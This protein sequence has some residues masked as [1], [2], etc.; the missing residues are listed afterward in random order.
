M[1]KLLIGFLLGIAAAMT[2]DLIALYEDHIMSQYQV[3]G[4]KGVDPNECHFNNNG[5]YDKFEKDHHTLSEVNSYFMLGQGPVYW[6][7]SGRCS[8]KPFVNPSAVG[9]LSGKITNRSYF[10]TRCSRFMEDLSDIVFSE[11]SN[12]SDE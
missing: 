8:L 4:C 2:P 6:V 5:W 9:D 1:C 11:V 3:D 12:D 10:G 7:F